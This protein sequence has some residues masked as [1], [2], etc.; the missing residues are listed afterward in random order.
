MAIRAVI[1]DYDGTSC[2]SWPQAIK[3]IRELLVEFDGSDTKSKELAIRRQWGYAAA[4]AFKN[5]LPHADYDALNDFWIKNLKLASSIK[6]LEL[7]NG[8]QET[9]SWL[10]RSN[11][12]RVLLTNRKAK[13]LAPAIPPSLNL[14][15]NFEIV[16]TF[17]DHKHAEERFIDHPLHITAQHAKPD[18]R[19][20][21]P[22]LQTLKRDYGI[23][24]T[25]IISVG[26]ALVDLEVA[27]ANNITFVGVLTGPL[28]THLR[29][30]KWASQKGVAINDDEIITSIK[31]LPVWIER[32]NS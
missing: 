17:F 29:W 21:R 15:E 31:N 5:A 7:I 4:E 18:R 6:P 20:F 28:N 30:I 14:T 32:M 13:H 19:A 12:V 10:S 26:D 27:R 24:A 2:D 11:I 3:I 1:L 22:V 8:A 23:T 16:Q 9:L 25:E